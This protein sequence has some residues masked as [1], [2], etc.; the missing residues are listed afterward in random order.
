MKDVYM[1]EPR[2]W[3]TWDVQQ[4][5]GLMHLP[6]GSMVTFGLFDPRT[7]E[8][9]TQFNWRS[10]VHRVGPHAADGSY[11]HID[12][13][14]GEAVV[15]LE[16]AADGDQLVCRAQAVHNPDGVLLV[17]S[18]ALPWRA[19]RATHTLDTVPPALAGA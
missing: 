11:C 19:S 2:G 17:L 9:H 10:G 4:V 6:S 13:Q 18:T 7:G 3:N 14:W 16:Y 5:N 1:I 12:L 15:R 8:H